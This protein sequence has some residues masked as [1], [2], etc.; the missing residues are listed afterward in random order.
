[1][2][3]NPTVEADRL[4]V[5]V[6]IEPLPSSTGGALYVRYGD[7]TG[8]I[9]VDPTLTEYDRLDAIG[10]ELVHHERG[11]GAYG[12]GHAQFTIDRI[13]EERRVWR[14]LAARRVPL[15]ALAEFCDAQADLGHGVGPVEVMAEFD[16]TRRVAKEA[17]HLLTQYERGTR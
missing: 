13:R 5:D 12:R 4:D 10:H 11:G 17:L 7:G 1:M 6:I 3:W 15:D 16:V 9:A 14:I 2:H 8:V